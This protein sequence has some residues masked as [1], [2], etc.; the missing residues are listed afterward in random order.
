MAE[1]QKISIVI[2]TKAEL[3]QI[4]KL[5]DE[6]AKVRAQMGEGS[7]GAK[8]LDDQLGSLGTTISRGVVPQTHEAHHGISLLGLDAHKTHL[9]V[10]LLGSTMG[11]AGHAL[12]FAFA[13]WQLLAIFAVVMAIKEAKEALDAYNE[14]LDKIAEEAAKPMDGGIVATQKAWDEAKKSLGEYLDKLAH[15]GDIKDPTQDA[16][17]KEKELEA[18][19][20]EAIKKLIEAEGKLEEQRIRTS[21]AGF[22]PQS[23]IEADVAAAQ[24][25]TKAKVESLEE[26]KTSNQMKREFDRNYYA[27]EELV[28]EAAE[29]RRK[30]RELKEKEGRRQEELAEARKK[31]LPDSELQKTFKE[32][33]ATVESNKRTRDA[34]IA[35]ASIGSVGTGMGTAIV[36]A[37]DKKNR[38]ELD[39]TKKTIED[40]QKIIDQD[41]KSG[42]ADAQ[43]VADAER[44]ASEKDA[45]ALKA[46]EGSGAQALANIRAQQKIEIVQE[47]ANLTVTDLTAQGVTDKTKADKLKELESQTLETLQAKA[48]AAGLTP[49]QIEAGT[50]TKA[51]ARTGKIKPEELGLLHEKLHPPTSSSATGATLGS[52]TQTDIDE[53]IKTVSL[54][55]L[56]QKDFKAMLQ[57]AIAREEPQDKLNDQLRIDTIMEQAQS[58]RE[59][60]TMLVKR[61]DRDASSLGVVLGELVGVNHT[62]LDAVGKKDEF[63]ETLR[64]DVE[65]LKGRVQRLQTNTP[66]G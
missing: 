14:R 63:I 7:A 36:D 22:K 60:V 9:A 15:A 52:L 13:G 59:A 57:E 35:L 47:N 61:P 23:E 32:Q 65:N 45:A 46:K 41:K 37:N 39:R 28:A 19:K 5:R 20:L 43:K 51:Q 18:A 42:V 21:E 3:E 34:R 2:H 38:E 10:R 29:A 26:H 17:K 11:E 16:I 66:S 53:G 58:A 30:A 64:K 6:L 27:E 40:N 44:E 54:G 4:T 50:L 1:D 55:A 8:L 25:R 56:S 24:A 33:E 48:A 62:I 31:L 49:E 12:H